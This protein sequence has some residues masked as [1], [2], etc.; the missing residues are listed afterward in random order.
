MGRNGNEPDR[1]QRGSTQSWRMSGVSISHLGPTQ[2]QVLIVFMSITIW[3][4]SIFQRLRSLALEP[5]K[6]VEDKNSQGIATIA[7]LVL[8]YDGKIRQMTEDALDLVTYR[9]DGKVCFAGRYLIFQT[10]DKYFDRTF[11]NEVF[12]TLIHAFC[13]KEEGCIIDAPPAPKTS[14][15]WF[16]R[17]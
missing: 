11:M 2:R 12:D 8:V 16:S 9:S 13:P 7:E 15:D 10:D 14:I 17:I 3:L 1:V 5:I 6:P 4:I